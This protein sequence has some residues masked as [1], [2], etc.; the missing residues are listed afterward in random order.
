M[1]R[2]TL[3]VARVLGVLGWLGLVVLAGAPAVRAQGSTDAGEFHRLRAGDAKAAQLLRAGL[4]RSATFR[5]MADTLEH[6]DLVVY[7]E[8]RPIPLPG[9][10]QLLAATPGCRRVRITVR[11]PGL[12]TDLVAW[13]GH[14]LWHAVKLAGTP[15]VRDQESLWRYYQRIGGGGQADS[16]VETGQAQETW[17]KVLYELRRAR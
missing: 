4:E 17:T 11:V 14:E 13:L 16:H 7:V 15:E 9:Q 10:L 6:S 2:K 8:T 1:D 12:D 5:A 3:R